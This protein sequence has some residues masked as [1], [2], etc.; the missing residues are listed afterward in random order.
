M[1]VSSKQLNRE[2]WRVPREKKGYQTIGCVIKY[3]KSKGKKS[4]KDNSVCS[5]KY[6]W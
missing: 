1:K 2:Q 6:E 5:I 4:L 3:K